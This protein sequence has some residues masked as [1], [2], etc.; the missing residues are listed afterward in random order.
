MA[1]RASSGDAGRGSDSFIY[2]SRIGWLLY[3][4]RLTTTFI[5]AGHRALPYSHLRAK[6]RLLALYRFLIVVEA[7]H[8]MEK[9]RYNIYTI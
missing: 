3:P 6:S 5:I 4:G 7:T 9:G 1:G 2:L 8:C